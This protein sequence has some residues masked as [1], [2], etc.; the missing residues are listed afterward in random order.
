[1]IMLNKLNCYT[2]SAFFL[3]FLIVGIL[4]YCFTVNAQLP[5]GYTDELVQSDYNTIMGTVFTDDAS[6][7]FVWEKS[8]KIFVS[9]FNG[10]T[11]VKQTQP[12]LDISDEVGDW[13]DFGL[14]SFCLDP[15][16]EN[17]GLVYLFYVVDRH[18]LMH[19]GTSNYNLNTNE[20]FAASL[21]R[22]SRYQI[23]LTSSPLTTDY[24]SRFILLGESIST[25]V[26]L[27]HES[28]AGGT[29]LFG[30]DGTLIVSTGDNASYDAVDIGSISHTY[31]QQAIDDGIM[32]PEENVGSFRS[33][34]I[35]SLC[36]KILRLDP[37]TGNGIA[38]NPFYEPDN[39]RS[40]KSRM[41]AMGLRNPFRISLQK[42]SGSNDPADA[43]PGTLFVA[44]VG[45][46]AW[47]E[48]HVIDKPG[49]NAGWPLYEGQTIMTNYWNA[50]II[51]PDENNSLFK[52]N[53][54]Q[55]TSFV[56]DQN[57]VSRRFVHNRPEIAWRHGSDES[58]VPWFNGTTP[59]SPRIGSANAPTTGVEFRGSTGVGGTCIVGNALGSS[60]NGKYFF[61]DYLR[62]WIHVATLNDGSLN[63]FSDVSQ[64]APTGFGQGIVQMMQNPIDGFVY[65]VNI[66][67]DELRRITF[68]GPKWTNE[69]MD[70]SLD[71][72]EDLDVNE[73]FSN[74]LLSFS[75]T[76][77]CGTP[78]V[79]NNS[80]GL[81]SDCGNSVYEEVT[82]T[83]A[84]ECGNEISKTVTFEII[85]STAPTWIN[86]PEDTS[87]ECSSDILSQFNDWLA[88]FS[89]IDNC[90]T[91]TLTHNSDGLITCDDTK[92]V[93]FTLQDACGNSNV[94]TANF[95]VETTLNALDEV[96]QSIS[97]FPNPTG[98]YFIISG[99]KSQAS[100]TIYS[101]TGQQIFKIQAL[102]EENI[103]V[104]LVAGLY[105]VK[106]VTG[107]KNSV[108]RLIIK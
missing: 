62:N 47:E 89:G 49:L 77:G 26:P 3:K 86:S 22:V 15:D 108:K 104:D 56:D 60:M 9:N 30:D 39:P 38:S 2:N 84:D 88:S 50:N 80:D 71:C 52:D 82:F 67:N 92:I 31:Y 28:H 102:N 16:F 94:L 14:L 7:M 13:R 61:T 41:Y 93:E 43:N 48:L 58:R 44:D 72:E 19:F 34:Q 36:G 8:G 25:G 18:H 83:L 99:L 6:K 98:K 12:V 27:T 20:Y 81:I 90:N 97:I 57:P 4:L 103:Q 45:W 37:N 29:I 74:W 69:P 63:W 79:S 100:V 21:S 24:N 87:I 105:L 17:N 73:Q 11:Y 70:L 101:V 5:A 75:G 53:C 55:P 1:M 33:Q 95:T 42:G 23:N 54:L 40:A 64:F 85:D 76:V 32:R 107:D 51:N 10:I 65:Y 59:T 66:F 96:A 68:D 35:T 46:F 91:T 106:I 78:N